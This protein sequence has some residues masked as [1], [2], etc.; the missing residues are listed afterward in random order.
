MVNKFLLFL[1]VFSF[2]LTSCRKEND[3]NPITPNE[4]S[5]QLQRIQSNANFSPRDS[6][7]EIV[8]NDSIWLFGGFEPNRTNEVW[9]S[10]DGINWIQ[11]PNAPWTPRNLM[12]VVLFQGLSSTNKFNL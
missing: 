10:S 4:V 5:Y 6:G 8:F 7:G 9:C 12:S 1:I 11:K 3:G 2:T